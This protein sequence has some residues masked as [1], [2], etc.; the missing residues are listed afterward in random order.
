MND[1]LESVCLKFIIHHSS[2]GIALQRPDGV[3]RE[4]AFEVDVALAAGDQLTQDAADSPVRAP[5]F[6]HPLRERR[7][8]EIAVEAAAHLRRPSQFPS[9]ILAPPSFVVE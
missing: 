7:A 4:F 5:E 8:P 1:E 6:D 2:F 9:E 3:A